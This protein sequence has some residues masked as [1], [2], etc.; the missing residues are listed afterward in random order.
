MINVT[1]GIY[2]AGGKIWEEATTEQPPLPALLFNGIP[3]VDGVIRISDD[4]LLSNEIEDELPALIRN[5]CFIV[6]REF[7]YQD[8]TVY[9]F[10]SYYGQI[11][12][13]KQ[14]DKILVT[15]SA[16]VNTA[17][18]NTQELSRALY[19]CGERFIDLLQHMKNTNGETPP[20]L[21]LIDLLEEVRLPEPGL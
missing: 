14:E 21:S 12:F 5:L 19:R 18:Y 15:G 2:L 7:L 20:L 10:H 9:N 1:F 16:G 6:S 8:H 11:D 13:S 3:A 4:D 17:L